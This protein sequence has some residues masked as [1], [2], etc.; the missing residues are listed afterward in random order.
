MRPTRSA[1]Q[2]EELANSITHGIGLVL[3]IAGFVVLLVFAVLRGGALQIVSCA[4]YGSTLV[5]VYA[6]STLYHALPSPG[7][8]RALK[9]FDHCAI[10]LLIAGTYTPFTLVTL[11]GG[12]GWSLFSIVWALAMAGIVFKFWFIDHFQILSTAVYLAMGW[13][14]L[15]AL[16]P[17]LSSIPQHGIYW[18]LAGG[19]ALFDRCRILRRSPPSLRPRDLARLCHSRECLPLLRRPLLRDPPLQNLNVSSW[20][21]T[22]CCAFVSPGSP[23]RFTAEA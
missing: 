17:L 10:Y 9:I 8:K 7:T 2:I 12:W 21:A 20:S 6:A 3:S 4:V 16:K 14:A 1:M 15:I 5:C 13:I 18:L 22:A 11:R 19:L 23:G